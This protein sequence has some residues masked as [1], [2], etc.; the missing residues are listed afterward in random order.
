MP[1]LIFRGRR[2]PRVRRTADRDRGTVSAMVSVLLA[3]GVLLGSLA[4]VVD[5]G[6]IYVEREELQSGADAAALAIARA[7]A[8]NESACDSAASIEETAAH[9]GDSNASDGA[10][11]VVEICG[12]LP[13]LLPTCSSPADNLT[14]CLGTMPNVP[15]NFVEVRLGTRLADGDFALPPTFAQT[16]AGNSGFTGT[17][18]GACARATWDTHTPVRILGLTISTCDFADATVDGTGGGTSF[19]P[20][21][22][23]PPDPDVADERIVAA[24]PEESGDCGAPEA[25]WRPAGPAGWLAGAGA[26]CEITSPVGTELAG[27]YLHPTELAP[28][29]A[30][31]SRL[32]SAAAVHELVYLPVHDAVRGASGEIRFRLVRLAPVVVT[33]FSFGPAGD[34]DHTMTSWL[35]T[36]SAISCLGDPLRTGDD[37]CVLG[38][39]VGPSIPL[40]DIT[41][42][43]KVRL[44]G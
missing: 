34:T 5:V 7:C 9:Y 20:M 12:Y 39:F 13:G 43:S 38:L 42:D 16:M 11:R 2:W 19:A 18:V 33:G 3:G 10:A 28:T 15:Q 23:Y 36:P 1:V 14:A 25:P 22:P 8:V 40:T 27:G 17:D 31:E 44:I 21:P 37:Q 32:R 29:V 24:G 4:L 35:R 26:D 30:C 41:M 6:R